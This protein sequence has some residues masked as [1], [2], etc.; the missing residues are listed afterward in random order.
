ME[1]TN[2]M[3]LEQLRGNGRQQAEA[4]KDLRQY[5]KRGVLNYLQTRS[6]LHY[7]AE[8]ELQQMSE[9]FTQEALL[10]IHTNLDT[11]QGR[12][13]FTMWA[14]KIATNHTISQLRRAKWRDLSLDTMTDAGTALQV[15]LRVDT[16]DGSNP[17]IKSEQSQVWQTITQVIN[18]DLTER[19]R[20]VLVA[21]HFE[22]IPTVH[23]A[24]LLNTNVNNIYKLMHDA[25][26]KLKRRLLALGLEPKYILYLFGQ[27][28][29]VGY[30]PPLAALVPPKSSAAI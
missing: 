22:N 17:E 30:W 28:S 14:S 24:R 10:K 6:D 11:F 29:S 2:E 8:T 16:G 26:L 18:N 19:Q 27:S 21:V 12:S 20:Q 7:L 15:I 5:L 25:R 4:I 3:W 23:V 9:D 13:K 1:R